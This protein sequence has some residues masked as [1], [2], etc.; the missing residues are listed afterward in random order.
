MKFESITNEWLDFIVKCRKEEIHQYDI[1]E[2]P[3]ADDTV[4]NYVDDF[5]YVCSLIEYIARKTKI[6]AG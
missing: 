1:V 2:G 4:W 6:G 5:F 3:M